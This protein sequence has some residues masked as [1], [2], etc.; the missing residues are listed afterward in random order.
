MYA[1]MIHITYACDIRKVGVQIMDKG[2]RHC[3]ANWKIHPYHTFYLAEKSRMSTI[4]VSLGQICVA[5]KMNSEKKI[6]QHL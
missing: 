4:V 2:L 5:S 3:G 6:I 1:L